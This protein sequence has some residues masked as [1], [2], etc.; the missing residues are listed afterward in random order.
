ML[1]F[2]Q[3]SKNDNAVCPEGSIFHGCCFQKCILM[4]VMLF[5]RNAKPDFFTRTVSRSRMRRIR[6]R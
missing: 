6:V 4:F 2:L 5:Q 3:T 1:S